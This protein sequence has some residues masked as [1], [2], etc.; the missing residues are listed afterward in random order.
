LP[1]WKI[2]EVVENPPLHIRPQLDECVYAR[3][4]TAR[5]SYRASEANNLIS[6]FKIEPRYRN[7]PRWRHKEAAI[8]QFADELAA[9]ITRQIPHLV[10]APIPTSTV[11]SDPGYDHRLE[12]MLATFGRLRPDIPVARPL[13]VRSSVTASHLGGGRDI[14]AIADNLDWSGIGVQCETLILVD[15]VLTTGA[16]FRACKQ[17]VHEH[18]PGLRVVG[19]FWARTIWP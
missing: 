7:T 9:G 4:Y 18:H 17:K 6:N 10:I 12:G 3:E 16:H 14:Q 13:A 15:D 8:Q 11:R 2:L 5:G 19:F 1:N